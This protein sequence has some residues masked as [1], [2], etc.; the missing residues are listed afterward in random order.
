M[1][2]KRTWRNEREKDKAR[3]AW[4]TCAKTT[5]YAFVRALLRL[6][7]GN[8]VLLKDNNYM[9]EKSAFKMLLRCPLFG[10]FGDE[11]LAASGLGSE[12]LKY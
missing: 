10:S 1:K 7:P 9:E 6:R 11:R 2:R 12:D 4:F 8:F 3:A 5:L